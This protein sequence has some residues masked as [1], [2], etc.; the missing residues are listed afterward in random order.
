MRS[1]D[2]EALDFA[3]LSDVLNRIRN[4][5]NMPDAKVDVIGFDTCDLAT[6]EIA[7]PD[8]AV[9]ALPGGFANW[10][11]DSGVALRHR[12]DGAA[13]AVRASNGAS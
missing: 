8:A 7:F 1:G 2:I 9:R 3:E 6:V 11:T 10:N 13:Q 4:R 5:L 12:L